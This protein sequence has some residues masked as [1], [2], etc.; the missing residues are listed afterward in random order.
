MSLGRRRLKISRRISEGRSIR[1]AWGLE[2]F[3]DL[4]WRFFC[5]LSVRFERSGRV[6]VVSIRGSASSAANSSFEVRILMVFTSIRKVQLGVDIWRGVV[7]AFPAGQTE[8][9]VSRDLHVLSNERPRLC[10]K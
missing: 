8:I 4:R 6:A 7:S 3:S 10:Y 9:E 5:C 1:V 2:D